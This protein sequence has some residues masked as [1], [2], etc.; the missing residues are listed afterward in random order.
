MKLDSWEVFLTALVSFWYLWLVLGILS[1]GG[2]LFYLLEKQKLVKSGIADI[3]SMDGKKFEKYLEV[4]FERLGYKVERTRHIGDYGADLVTRKNDIK[5]V[6][7]AKRHRGSVGI[8]A[9]QEAVAS[10]GY[11][12]CDKAMVVTNS[13]FTEQAKQ[14][15][16]KNDVELWDRR[17]LVGALLKVKEEGEIRIVR[18]DMFETAGTDSCSKCVI[19]GMAVSDKVRQYCLDRPQKFKDKIYCYEHQKTS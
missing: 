10:K 14:L 5:T 17:D 8:K 18:I 7:Q 6:I 1:I 16:V 3:D 4:L 2:L 9:I 12:G 11:Y 13:S 15:A 19:C